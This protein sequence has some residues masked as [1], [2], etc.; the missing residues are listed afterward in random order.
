MADSDDEQ[1]PDQ[2]QDARSGRRTIGRQIQ[3]SWRNWAALP[4]YEKF[5]HLVVLV[6]TLVIAVVVIAALW[7]LVIGVIGGRVLSGTVDP[8]DQSMFQAI[9]GMILTVI[10]ALEFKR[11][12]LVAAERQFGIVQVRAVV[13]IGMLAVVRKLIILDLGTIDPSKLLALAAASLALG[14]V[15]WLVRDQD[16]K[17]RTAQAAM[18]RTGRR[19]REDDGP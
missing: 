15:Y 11:S 19:E 3:Q 9:F 8:A 10:I 16:R 4:F 6:L 14:I 13:L 17:E 12:I 1:A 18:E 2:A 7:N 5:E